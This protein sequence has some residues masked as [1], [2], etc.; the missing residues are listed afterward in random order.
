MGRVGGDAAA[1]EAPRQ[2]ER[3]QQVLQLGHAV[4]AKR[5]VLFRELQVLEIHARRPMRL[6]RD[7][8]DA[9]LP[10]RF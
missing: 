3:E 2:L 8:D 1:R 7:I 10:G 4:G 9:G 5:R 6:R